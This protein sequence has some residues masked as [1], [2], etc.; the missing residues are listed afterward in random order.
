M[1]DFLRRYLALSA[2]ALWLGGTTLYAGWVI[3]ISHRVV[4]D[5]AQVGFVTRE[6]TAV[7]QGIGAVACA[8]LAWNAFY[9]ARGQPR[10][11]AVGI[12]ATWAVAAGTLVALFAMHAALEATLDL[13]ARR[14]ADPARFRPLHEGYQAVLTVQ[15]FAGLL[16]LAGLVIAGP[17]KGN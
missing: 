6:V 3:R 16:H 7:L 14:V 13:S 1:L 12:W 4:G 8:L 17:K 11:L 5:S 9:A 10:P 15:W 2:L